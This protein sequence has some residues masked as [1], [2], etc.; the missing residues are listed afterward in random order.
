M[1]SIILT[2]ISDYADIYSI[3]DLTLKNVAHYGTINMDCYRLKKLKIID[4]FIS[5]IRFEHSIITLTYRD[6]SLVVTLC[7]GQFEE[8]ESLEVITSNDNDFKVSG[9]GELTNLIK[10]NIP[11]RSMDLNQF[12]KLPTS[13]EDITIYTSD[14]ED[15]QI[16]IINSK[17][18]R[19][20]N[21]KKL[22]VYSTDN[23]HVTDIINDVKNLEELTLRYFRKKDDA[24]LILP[25]NYLPR[26]VKKVNLINQCKWIYDSIL[27][28]NPYI[29]ELSMDA[30]DVAA[31]PDNIYNAR[32]IRLN[33]KCWPDKVPI[34]IHKIS[35]LKG[36]T[37]EDPKLSN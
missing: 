10:L 12:L 31:M 8:L 34:N 5:S 25:T 26:S 24:H 36:L 2:D 15:E 35:T 29:E 23:V 11:Y 4:D 21:M 9:I 7:I 20:D 3:E 16:D 18:N 22:D 14:R 19:Y 17:L 1:N 37:I 6:L 30:S 33:I 13:L 28:N 27:K 32:L